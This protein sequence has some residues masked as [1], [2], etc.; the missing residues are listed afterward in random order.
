MLVPISKLHCITS[1]IITLISTNVRTSLS[2]ICDF[3]DTVPA[4]MALPTTLTLRKG[5]EDNNDF[6][7]ECYHSSTENKKG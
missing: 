5:P 7:N 3:H 2:H 1:E 4:A 6:G